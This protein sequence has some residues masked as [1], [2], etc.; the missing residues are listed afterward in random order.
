MSCHGWLSRGTFNRLSWGLIL[1]KTSLASECTYDVE[2]SLTYHA[3]LAT[4]IT[5]TGVGGNN[6]AYHAGDPSLAV[7]YENWWGHLV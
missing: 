4:S 3:T 7:L 6:G 5:S 2:A 1:P